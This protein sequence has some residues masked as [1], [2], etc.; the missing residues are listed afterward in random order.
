[1]LIIHSRVAVVN[2]G[3][4][5]PNPGGSDPP[6]SGG[7][8]N[9]TVTRRTV[10]IWMDPKCDYGELTLLRM[11]AVNGRLPRNPF[12]IRASIDRCVGEKITGAFPEARGEYYTLK[13]RNPSHVAK[14][15]T[16]TELV[17]N[18][19]VRII[20]HPTLNVSKCVVSCFDVIDMPDQEIL[21]SLSNQG[22]I[23]VRRFTRR[24]GNRVVNTPSMV[25]TIQGATPPDYIDFGYLRVSTRPYYPS[26]M[27]CYKC[28]SFGHTRTKCQAATICGNCARDDHSL[29]EGGTCPNTRFCRRCDSHEHSFSSRICPVFQK[30]KEIQR[31]RVDQGLSYPAAS[32][33]YNS[34]N[35]V[36]SYASVAN[37]SNEFA[38]AELTA[39]VGKLTKALNE[40]DERI[41]ALE[42]KKNTRM[43]TVAAN[44]T[45][46][47]LV[48]QV[49]Y[50]K[51]SSEKKDQEINVLRRL[52]NSL[53]NSQ[54]TEPLESS[55][56]TNAPKEQRK[57]KKSKGKETKPDE[58]LVNQ[59][60]TPKRNP[61]PA[62]RSN[63][64]V[65]NKIQRK[66]P[67]HVLNSIFS[68]SSLESGEE[69]Y[70]GTAEKN[71]D[72]DVAD[73]S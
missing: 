15:L 8:I 57:A 62:E 37:A 26:P 47:D 48:K 20:H 27:V 36:R 55:P 64:G 23:G 56:M 13:V 2:M 52:L 60:S 66:F 45:I 54:S 49:N 22:V 9:G 51:E 12:T 31:L 32:R 16:L 28:W 50:L 38:L 41:K 6:A 7:T 24:D 70:G 59:S 44:G 14:L 19:N 33:I 67:D 69:A 40:K 71:M 18:T 25:L 46:E 11:E 17:D 30:E 35:N 4:P 73:L 43:Q 10:P 42:T 61:S 72:I 53:R 34:Q 3:E 65:K 58:M 63:A 21:S 68:D 39:K 1:M 29:E 5:D